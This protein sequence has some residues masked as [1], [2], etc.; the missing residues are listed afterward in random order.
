MD[1]QRKFVF[2]FNIL[3]FCVFLGHILRIGFK[4]KNPEIPSVKMYKRELK[5]IEFPLTFKLCLLE[6]KTSSERYKR[7]GYDNA[8]GFYAGQSMFDSKY[9]GWNGHSSN[10]TTFAS[11]QGKALSFRPFEL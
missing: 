4:L 6:N 11:V 2:F 8:N 9:V 3:F 10:K 7:L 5:D 1:I